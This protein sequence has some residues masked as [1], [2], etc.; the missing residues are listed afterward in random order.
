MS[1]QVKALSNFLQRNRR[2]KALFLTSYF[3]VSWVFSNSRINSLVWSTKN[4]AF[5]KPRQL[6]DRCIGLVFA[7]WSFTHS[8]FP[9]AMFCRRKVPT[10]D[11]NAK[12]NCFL[13]FGFTMTN[14]KE[15]QIYL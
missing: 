14:T 13:M 3:K 15:S 5:R 11:K 10:K 12:E 2:R 7:L 9:K 1:K 4:L 8:K 6:Y